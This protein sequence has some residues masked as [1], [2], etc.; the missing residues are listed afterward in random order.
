MIVN[1]PLDAEARN[2]ISSM[3]YSRWSEAFDTLKKAKAEDWDKVICPK[4]DWPQFHQAR[5]EH[6]QKEFDLCSRLKANVCKWSP[7]VL[8]F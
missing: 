8:G 1:V 5:I 6:A 4:S 2:A 7:L 3:V